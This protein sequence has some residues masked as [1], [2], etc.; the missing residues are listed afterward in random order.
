MLQNMK[1]KRQLR[2]DAAL[3]AQRA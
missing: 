1:A 2:E 3:E